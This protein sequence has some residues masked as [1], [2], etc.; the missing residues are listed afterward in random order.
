MFGPRRE[1][2][3]EVRVCVCPRARACVREYAKFYDIKLK[4]KLKLT[5]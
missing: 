1:D 4:V 2:V 3:A 5:L